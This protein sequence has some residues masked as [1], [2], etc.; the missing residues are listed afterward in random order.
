[1]FSEQNSL[2]NNVS[3]GKNVPSSLLNT[4][5]VYVYKPSCTSSIVTLPRSEYCHDFLWGGGGGSEF[6][7]CPPIRDMLIFAT[8]FLE[9]EVQGGQNSLRGDVNNVLRG[10][11]SPVNN[12]WEAHSLVY[13][14]REDIVGERGHPTKHSSSL[15]L[16]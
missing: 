12:D 3:L 2:V 14:V 1:M 4:A 10:Q 11:N 8:S 5:I 16:F 13:N 9:L 15:E 7:L 6:Q